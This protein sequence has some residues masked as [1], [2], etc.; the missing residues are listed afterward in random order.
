MLSCCLLLHHN[1]SSPIV[2]PNLIAKDLK[3]GCATCFSHPHTMQ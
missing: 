3:A 2:L 1:D